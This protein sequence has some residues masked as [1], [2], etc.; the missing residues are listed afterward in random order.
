[1]PSQAVPKHLFREKLVLNVQLYLCCMQTTFDSGIE[2]QKEK[3]QQSNFP[4]N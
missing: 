3:I 4:V 1:M 2:Y